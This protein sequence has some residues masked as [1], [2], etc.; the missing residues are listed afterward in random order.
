MIYA[1]RL[2]CTD[3]FPDVPTKLRTKHYWGGGGQLPP[4]PAPPPPLATLVQT[5]CVYLAVYPYYGSLTVPPEDEINQEAKTGRRDPKMR[6][7]VLKIRQEDRMRREKGEARRQRDEIDGIQDLVFSCILIKSTW[8]NPGSCLLVSAR[9]LVFLTP[10]LVFFSW[11]ISSSGG[12]FK[13]PY[14]PH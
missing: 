9:L 8:Q 3:K 13:L 4:C 10:F 2:T 12:T 1:C 11:F 5:P 7:G 6:K 14:N